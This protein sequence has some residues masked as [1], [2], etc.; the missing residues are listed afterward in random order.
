MRKGIC[1]S[2]EKE[3]RFEMVNTIEDFN[4]RGE[5]IK[6][7]VKYYKCL[8]C[9]DEFEDPD[10]DYDP[11][12]E[13]Y[14]E[15][16]DRH[17]LIQPEEIRSFRK[18]YGLTQYELSKLLGW[19][20]AT[21]SR[22]ENGALQDETHEIALRLAMDPRN[23][24][25]LIKEAPGVISEEKRG[26][27]INELKEA[28][29]EAHSFERI[30]E[31]RFGEYDANEL[32][33]FRKLDLDKIFN[34]ILFFCKEGVFTTKLNKLLFYADFK[35]YKEYAV[36]ITG[37]RYEHLNFGP[38]PDKYSYYFAT[39]IHNNSL[40]IEEV[41]F[42]EGYTGEELFA[43][44]EPDLNIFLD[45]ELKILASVKEHFQ[46][47]TSKAI[48]HVVHKEKAFEET[49]YGQMISYEYAIDLQL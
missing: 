17:S 31:V 29:E 20:G 34:V 11:L 45:S 24:L 8:T 1:P 46:N 44:K 6:I 9:G 21:L 35:H 36:S 25:R 48:S 41:E 12:D 5:L 3:S 42:P 28:E 18:M 15:Y 4:V 40:R 49:Q 38:T 14:R 43:E 30:Y 23:L 2:C 16:R 27:L 19:G 13:A 47:F 7:E 39:L 33:G 32:S 37:V 10:S 22:Y 26:R